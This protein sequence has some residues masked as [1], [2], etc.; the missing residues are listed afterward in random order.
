MILVYLLISEGPH[1]LYLSSF[2]IKK[3]NETCWVSLCFFP[4]F[5]FY[6]QESV[7]DL[8]I[9]N[10]QLNHSG[11]YLCTVKTSLES[12]SADGDIVVRGEHTW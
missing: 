2:K 8:M 12:L 6:L 4:F 10:I 7:G 5:P 9:R 3:K 1:I 11:K